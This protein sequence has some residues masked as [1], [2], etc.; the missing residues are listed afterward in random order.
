MGEIAPPES[1]VTAKSWND[2]ETISA[3]HFAFSSLIKCETA[4]LAT[5]P[6]PGRPSISMGSLSCGFS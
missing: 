2:A 5:N 4:M 6:I 1:V 3:K